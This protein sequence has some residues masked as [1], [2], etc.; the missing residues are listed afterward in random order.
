MA[1]RI[2]GV[3]LV[4]VSLRRST[5]TS[6]F[7]AGSGSF[8]DFVAET[9][10]MFRSPIGTCP[11]RKLPRASRKVEGCRALQPPGVTNLAE[12]LDEN[13]VCDGEARGAQTQPRAVELHQAGLPQSFNS[14]PEAGI[15]LLLDAREVNSFQLTQA[16]E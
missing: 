13:F 6:G 7:D 8:A 1:R 14:V 11:E 9:P 5:A 4:T 3:G 10:C 2:S 16:E 12:Q 15:V